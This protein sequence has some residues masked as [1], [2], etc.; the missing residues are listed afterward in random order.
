MFDGAG[1]LFGATGAFVVFVVVFV[2]VVVCWVAVLVATGVLP[3]CCSPCVCRGGFEPNKL[4]KKL[5]IAANAPPLL[6]LAP[7]AVAD[8]VWLAVTVCGPGAVWVTEGSFETG[9]AVAGF[10]VTTGTDA[11]VL[12]VVVT[13]VTTTSS[14]WGGGLEAVDTACLPL[15]TRSFA[16]SIQSKNKFW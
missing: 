8:D 5:R 1:W 4:L 3:F 9:F 6:G 11:A 10:G 15:S 2:A 16:V 14:T 13:L 7:V 12:V